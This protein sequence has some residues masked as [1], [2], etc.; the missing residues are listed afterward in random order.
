[1]FLTSRQGRDFSYNIPLP[2]GSYELRL[3]F[4]ETIYGED[5]PEGGGESSR[6]FNISANNEPLVTDFDP[7]S[8]AGGDNTADAR[9]FKG[10]SPAP[11]GKL[12]LRFNSQYIDKAVAFVNGIEI[13]PLRPNATLPTR[14][15]ASDAALVD[16]SN[17]LWQP[18][19][20]CFGGRIRAERAPAADARVPELFRSERYGNFSYAI[21]V[22]DSTYTV[23]LYFSEHWF[24]LSE[25]APPVVG[26][27][28]G[29]RVFDVYCN[30][31]ALLRDFD[32]AK[33]SG[34]PLKGIRR[35][36][37]GLKPN[38]QGKLL[39][40]FVPKMNYACLNAIEVV[41]ENAGP[42]L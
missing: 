15:V 34:G 2:P 36:F 26:T 18:D 38:G 16:S 13:L 17:H 9:V 42:P 20:F 10:I 23:T 21:P 32:I 37:H 33:E 22:A 31:E 5:N 24:G 19:D 39:F 30:G 1:L 6:L 25:G 41:D 8:D 7:M 35:A 28:V 4:A 11:D 12:H 40:T 3:Y 27:G 29:G 14:W